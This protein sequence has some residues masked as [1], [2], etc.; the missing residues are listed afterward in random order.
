VV[1][2][3]RKG[4]LGKEKSKIRVL[5]PIV[6]A[7]AVVFLVGG[8]SPWWW[9]RLF[10]EKNINRTE[11]PLENPRPP[12]TPSTGEP[13]RIE[14]TANPQAIPSGGQAGI[15][16]FVFN[17]QNI[18]ISGA[19]V[20]IESGGGWFSSNGTT[21]VTGQTDSGGVFTTKWKAPNPALKGYIL[22]VTATRTGILDA[23][24]ECQVPIY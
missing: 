19:I 18:P 15:R 11:L 13:V 16:V 17:E 9:T 1:L 22:S 5:I 23:K 20:L 12:R 2:R 6:F 14:C 24:G 8:T 4:S 21:S 3:G 10:P 7:A